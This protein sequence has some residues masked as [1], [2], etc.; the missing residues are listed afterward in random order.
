MGRLLVRCAGFRVAGWTIVD[1][2][3]DC[4]V[5]LKFAVNVIVACTEP[6]VAFYQRSEGPVCKVYNSILRRA[7]PKKDRLLTVSRQVW[8]SLLWITLLSMVY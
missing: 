5:V 1:Q 8:Q 4:T 6:G 7:E 3:I 2:Q